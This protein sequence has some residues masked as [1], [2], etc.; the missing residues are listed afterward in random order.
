MPT[1]QKLW[2]S[3]VGTVTGN[4]LFN[5]NLSIISSTILA[6]VPQAL[7][8]YFYLL[9]NSILT[10]MLVGEEW[11]HFYLTRKRLRVSNPI[12]QQRS[13]YWLQVPYKYS[14]PLLALSGLLHWSAS[15]SLFVVQINVLSEY[16][17]QIDSS[18]NISTCGYSPIAI[19]ITTLIGLIIMIIGI[20]QGS[21]S[22]P[23][24][25]PLA[26]TCSA[27]ISAACHPPKDDVDAAFL[28]VQWGAVKMEN[29]QDE[30]IEGDIGHCTFT[31]CEVMAPQEGKQYR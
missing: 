26:G 10:S 6:N 20:A 5:M 29:G 13:T 19:M 28:P 16:P 11:T 2:H 17:R 24:G 1:N 15:Q 8:S 30:S 4:N 7:L 12:G 25:M 22:Y 27:A 31:S 21:R 9:F 14:L 3:G 23:A 18:Q